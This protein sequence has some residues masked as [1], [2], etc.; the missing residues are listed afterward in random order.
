MKYILSIGVTSLIPPAYGGYEG[1]LHGTKNDAVELMCR[2]SDKGYKAR[3]LIDGDASASRFTEEVERLANEAKSKDLVII[4]LSGH[5]GQLRDSLIID[6]RDGKDEY[7][8]FVER[9]MKDDEMNYLFSKFKRGV[10]LLVINDSCHSG[11]QYKSTMEDKIM[12]AVPKVVPNY[13][14]AKSAS[15]EKFDVKIKCGL[16]YIAG[17]ED[18]EVSYDGAKYNDQ[19]HGFLSATVLK[20]LDEEKTRKVRNL[21]KYIK[22]NMP[23]FQ[24]PKITRVKYWTTSKA[25]L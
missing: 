22:K 6:E 19:T 24:K 7:F 25:K 16:H 17:C 13:A 11:S 4:T 2:F 12:G 20:Y 14:I 3:I 1:L 21:A 15:K 8:C 9:P 10:R 23:S 5:G 18:K